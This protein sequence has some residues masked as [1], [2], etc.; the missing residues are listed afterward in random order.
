MTDSWASKRSRIACVVLLGFDYKLSAADLLPK[1]L[2]HATDCIVFAYEVF[3]IFMT[4]D[5]WAGVVITVGARVPRGGLWPVSRRQKFPKNRLVPE[6]YLKVPD[7]NE[8]RDLFTYRTALIKKKAQS[9]LIDWLAK[10]HSNWIRAYLILRRLIQVGVT[11]RAEGHTLCLAWGWWWQKKRDESW[12]TW[13]VQARSMAA[14]NP[15]IVLVEDLMVLG[16]SRAGKD[17]NVNMPLVE[18]KRS[19]MY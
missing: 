16:T 11:K 3:M 12:D 9:H 15:I 14:G 1:E 2:K 17:E 19:P 6:I 7:V 10:R 5:L 18:L 4:R 8:C 13:L